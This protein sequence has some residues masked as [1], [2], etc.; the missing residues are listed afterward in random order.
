MNIKR[1]MEIGSYRGVA[2]PPQ[3]AGARAAHAD[4]RAHA[5]GPAQGRDREEEG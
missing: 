1:L 5:Q 3:S 2:A 4:E